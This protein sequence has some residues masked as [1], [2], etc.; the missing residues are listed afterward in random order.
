MINGERYRTIT[1]TEQKR[2]G[3]V[4]H[5]RD[6]ASDSVVVTL[7]LAVIEYYNAVAVFLFTWIIV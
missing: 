2:P 5:S 7:E 4:L 6:V 3:Y 1:G